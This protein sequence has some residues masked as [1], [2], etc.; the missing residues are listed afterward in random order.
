MRIERAIYSVLIV[1]ATIVA[2]INWRKAALFA[3][4]NEELRAR[5]ETLEIQV[6]GTAR[7]LDIA[8][9]HSDKI[10][11][12]TAELMRLRNEV[13][14]LHESYSASTLTNAIGVKR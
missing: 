3:V 13:I 4:D 14:L 12:Q 6:A 2:V 9:R 8:K 10:R 11:D 1:A 7:L 5:I